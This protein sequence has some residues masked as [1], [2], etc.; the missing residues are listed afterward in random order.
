M[1]DFLW[2]VYFYIFEK[3]VAQTKLFQSIW[4][5]AYKREYRKNEGQRSNINS[6][7]R[8]FEV[9]VVEF[10][11]VAD[12]RRAFSLRDAPL[13]FGRDLKLVRNFLAEA[14]VSSKRGRRQVAAEHA[15][16]A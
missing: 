4:G 14:E 16:L 9:V 3:G 11:V 13:Q 6:T 7:D 8:T 5:T 1:T 15:A 2:A 12:S 10:A